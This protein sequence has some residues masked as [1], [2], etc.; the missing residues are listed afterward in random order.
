MLAH[1]CHLGY[2]HA[3]IHTRE[4]QNPH[5]ELA[6]KNWVAK[7]VMSSER[8]YEKAFREQ[9]QSMSREMGEVKREMHE[10]INSLTRWMVGLFVTMTIAI[11]V[12][13][14]FKG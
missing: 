11:I 12:A 6:D 8:G 1:G 7:E 14:L 10:A 2:F 4:T 5:V 13:V 9:M 3:M